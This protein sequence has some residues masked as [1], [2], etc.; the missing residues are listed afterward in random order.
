MNEDRKEGKKGRGGRR[1]GAGRK[2][3]YAKQLERAAKL[4]ERCDPRLAV[5]TE[6]EARCLHSILRKVLAA[7]PN[8][9]QNQIESKP[10]I[11]VITVE[12]G[13][14]LRPKTAVYGT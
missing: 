12:S 14:L 9:P 6:L 7:S 11:E 1:P 13:G 8:A 2:P 5:L 3:N 10:A 4:L